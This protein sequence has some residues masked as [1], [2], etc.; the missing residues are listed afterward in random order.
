[1][2]RKLCFIAVSLYFLIVQMSAQTTSGLMTGEIADSTGAV[3]L[4]AQIDVT[5][6]ATAQVRTTTSGSNGIYIVPLL[7]PGTYTVSVKKHGFAVDERRDV[8]LEVNQSDTVNF[9]LGI[10]TSAQ[11]VQVTGAAPLLNTTSATLSQV[12]DHNTTVNLPLNG[13]EFTQLTCRS[14]VRFES[15][16]QACADCLPVLSPVP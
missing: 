14:A 2:L 3:V 1:M 10:S 12:V 5:N 16:T 8:Q 11:I 6:Q 4:G 7:P 15:E 9:K 13:R